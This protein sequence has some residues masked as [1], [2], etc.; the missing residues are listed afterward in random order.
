MSGASAPRPDGAQREIHRIVLVSGSP[1]RR[2]LLE[3][4]GL[5]FTVE[6]PDVDESV[7]RRLHPSAYVREVARRKIV[8]YMERNRR[9]GGR[10]NPEKPTEWALA[11]DTVVA[12]G[13]RII[14]KPPDRAVAEETLR[15]LS[16]RSHRVI[17]ALALYN[18]T[19]RRIAVET[20]AT[21]VTFARLS[22][23]E[24]QWY[25]GS[26]EWR[27]VAGGYR[28]QGRGSVLVK[29]IEGSYSNVVGLPLETFYGMVWLQG[30]KLFPAGE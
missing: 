10:A 22:E 6:A 28:I 19:S 8:A 16:G 21:K 11:A 29:R 17:T 9:D 7:G 27:D 24:I 15:S 25:L 2:E 3:Q 13:R 1:R 26:E 18:P 30:Y 4:I 20:A 5:S 23:E 12:L 14:G